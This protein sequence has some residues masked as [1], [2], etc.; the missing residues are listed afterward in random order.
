MNRPGLDDLHGRLVDLLNSGE[1]AAVVDRVL[2]QPK[3][4]AAVVS[5]SYAHPNGFRKIVVATSDDGMR[6]RVHHWSSE[7]TDPSN[8]HNHRWSLASAVIVGQL[9]SA[10]FADAMVGELEI[11]RAHV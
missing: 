9:H 5:R 2:R 1:A 11:G 7:D 4:L 8:V 3:E 10:L 6:L